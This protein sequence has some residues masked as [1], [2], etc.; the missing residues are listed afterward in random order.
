MKRKEKEARKKEDEKEYLMRDLELL[1]EGILK[2][3][4]VVQEKI[5]SENQRKWEVMRGGTGG[6]RY[7]IPRER[8]T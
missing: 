6:G 1:R 7:Q 5:R 2:E 4:A 8:I 3:A